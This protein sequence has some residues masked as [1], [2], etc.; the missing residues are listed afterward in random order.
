MPFRLLFPRQYFLRLKGNPQTA[1]MEY[2]EFKRLMFYLVLCAAGMAS[3]LLA[4]LL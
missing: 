3:A 4:L 2:N 1:F